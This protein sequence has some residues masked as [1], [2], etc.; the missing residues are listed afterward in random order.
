MKLNKNPKIYKTLIKMQRDRKD[1][2]KFQKK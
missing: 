2:E 1:D